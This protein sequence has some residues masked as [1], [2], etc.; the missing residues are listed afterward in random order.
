MTLP[1]GD[2]N[3][4]SAF[5]HSLPKQYADYAARSGHTGADEQKLFVQQK[6]QKLQALVVSGEDLEKRAFFSTSVA[7]PAAQVGTVS[8]ATRALYPGC[9][10][11]HEVKPGSQGAPEITKPVMFDRWLSHGGFNHAKHAKVACSQCHQAEKSKASADIILPA[12]ETC[13]IC[14]STGGGVADSCTTCHVY[15]TRDRGVLE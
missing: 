4:V 8:G 13:A 3:F 1:H 15:H 12:R 9:V 5:L 11:C 6:L 7:G 14:H 10:Y 2:P